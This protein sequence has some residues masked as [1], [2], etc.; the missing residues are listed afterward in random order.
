MKP[1]NSEE[2]SPLQIKPSKYI[3]KR[4][5]DGATGT[6]LGSKSQTPESLT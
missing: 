6:H 4:T 5:V 1:K 2:A 3:F